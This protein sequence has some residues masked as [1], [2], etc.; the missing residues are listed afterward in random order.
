MKCLIYKRAG[1]F[2]NI[3]FFENERGSSIFV[4][5]AWE[6]FENFHLWTNVMWMLKK[7][8]GKLGLE[9]LVPHRPAN[10]PS[11]KQVHITNPRVCIGNASPLKPLVTSG[12]GL[13]SKGSQL[14]IFMS[15]YCQ[16]ENSW[17]WINAYFFLALFYIYFSFH[18]YWEWF[19]K[20][21]FSSALVFFVGR[22]FCFLFF[23]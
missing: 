4:L 9:S 15:K 8:R 22:V 14:N 11:A 18:F 13:D 17:C 23:L 3:V 7:G 2:S 16:P 21:L 12:P 6:L 10:F 20:E 5:G 19:S 1:D